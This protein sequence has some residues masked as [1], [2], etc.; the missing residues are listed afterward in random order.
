M[1]EIPPHLHGHLTD[2]AGQP[3]AGRTLSD[4]RW[5]DDDGS[6][7][8]A[9]S[10]ALTAFRAGDAGLAAVIDTLRDVR[11]LVPLVAELGEEGVS[12]AGLK[13]DKS[14]ELS[15]VTVEGP[16]GR[17]IVPVFSSVAAMNAWDADARPVPVDS[18][19]IALATVDEQTDLLIL[20]PGSS[21]EFVVRRPAVWAI[22]QDAPYVEPWHDPAVLERAK[23]LLESE[24]QLVGI[25]LRPGDP[26]AEFAGPELELVL[27]V[28]E[29][30]DRD[31]L[32]ELV[33][34]VQARLAADETF[35]TNVDSISLR[36]AAIAPES[37]GGMTPDHAEETRKSAGRREWWRRGRR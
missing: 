24:P 11:L 16:D 7:P 33:A 22:A 19:Q 25:D 20:D 14:A 36:L 5:K 29:G 26:A 18:R 9:L 27:M 4:N 31:A 12:D 32:G 17:G 1:V 6:A 28:P 34:R 13:V 21:S 2:S 37:P 3:W 23:A 10:D 15:I 30:A 8:A 35:V